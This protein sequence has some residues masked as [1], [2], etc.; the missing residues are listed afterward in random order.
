MLDKLQSPK[1]V[2]NLLMERP[3]CTLKRH[4]QQ[5]TRNY[6]EAMIRITEFVVHVCFN[7]LRIVLGNC[8]VV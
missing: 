4:I 6:S 1:K 7:I 2:S 5:V 3:Y 8:E